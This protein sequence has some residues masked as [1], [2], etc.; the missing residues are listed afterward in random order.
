MPAAPPQDSLAGIDT[1]NRTRLP[2]TRPKEFVLLA[3]TKV[4][5]SIEW[6]RLEV[7]DSIEH[8]SYIWC[9]EKELFRYNPWWEKDLSLLKGLYPREAASD[10]VLANLN[11][12][13]VVF[14]TGLRR[15]GKTSLMRM[16]ILHLIEHLEI[17]AEHI[18]YVNLDDYLLKDA[19]ILDIVEGFRKMQRLDKNQNVFLFLDEITFVRDYELQLKNLYD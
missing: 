18:L 12:R 7:F 16:C 9:M 2:C 19:S 13:Q 8:F 14:L 4:F 10:R 15:I 5:D 17:P 1:G 6:Y 3:P 11:N